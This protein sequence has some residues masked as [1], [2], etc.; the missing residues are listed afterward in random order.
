MAA[1]PRLSPRGPITNP[2]GTPTTDFVLFLEKTAAAVEQNLDDLQQI[3]DDLAATQ[4]KIIDI[5]SG[6]EEFT[7]LNV[8]GAT[9]NTLGT[10]AEADIGTGAGQVAA[11][12]D[13][14]ITDA[15]NTSTGGVVSGATDFAA[16]ATFTNDVDLSGAS[17]RLGSSNAAADSP[18]TAY[19]TILD[20]GGVPR[21]LAVIA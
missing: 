19:I 1:L 15:L 18:I 2:D 20:S 11:A 16:P 21:K 14:R 8:N 12:N 5:L 10:A 9:V 6:S 3:V 4:Q 13:P 7:A 17:V